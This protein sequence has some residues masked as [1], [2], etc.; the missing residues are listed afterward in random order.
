M[1]FFRHPG[2]GFFSRLGRAWDSVKS[3]F[4][5]PPE[6]RLRPP[7]RR[8][9]AV[10]QLEDRC[11]LSASP[12]GPEFRVNTYT[13]GPQQT[14]PQTPQAVAMNPATGN[15]VVT[16]SSQGQNGSN[17]NVYAQRYSAAG[18]RQGSEF[19]VSTP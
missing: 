10:Q 4:A 5:M 8:L 16:W 11:L 7:G 17:W 14:F 18:V 12:I 15:Y 2:R 1:D 6:E 3:A 13:H 9:R 19:L